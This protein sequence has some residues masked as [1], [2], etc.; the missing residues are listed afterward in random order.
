MKEEKN[1]QISSNKDAN[2]LYF[3]PSYDNISFYGQN[4]DI[5]STSIN[6]NTI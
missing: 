6:I 4:K 2:Y 3:W 5:L 1:I